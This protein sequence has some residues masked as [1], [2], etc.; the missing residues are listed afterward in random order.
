MK[1]CSKYLCIFGGGA[2]RG[3]SYLGVLKAFEKLSFNP[4]KIAGSSVGSVFAAFYALDIPL[5]EMN[6]ILI[7]INFELFKDINFSFAPTFALSK[8]GVFLD[9]IRNLIEKYYKTTT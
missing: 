8:G 5:E 4:Q 9:W 2:V 7:N 3:Y 6:K 1:D